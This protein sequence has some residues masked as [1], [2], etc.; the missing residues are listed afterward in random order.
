MDHVHSRRRR[1]LAALTLTVLFAVA[2]ALPAGA[3]GNISKWWQF[4]RIVWHDGWH[5]SKALDTAFA[6]WSHNHPRAG[7][8]QRLE[9]SHL[10]RH[11]WR[12]QHFHRAVADQA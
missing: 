12:M 9:F 8:Y 6:R 2:P 11:R 3:H 10:L 5:H 4:D 1:V 7:K